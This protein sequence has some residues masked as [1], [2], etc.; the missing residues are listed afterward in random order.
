MKVTSE[1]L[2]NRSS[3][4]TFGKFNLTENSLKYE[5]D[6]AAIRK[7]FYQYSHQGDP[8]CFSLSISVTIS[9]HLKLITIKLITN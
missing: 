7:H 9:F 5:K 8:S 1:H 2:N 6:A 3:V 4:W